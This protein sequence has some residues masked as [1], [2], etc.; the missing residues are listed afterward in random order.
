VL[1]LSQTLLRDGLTFSSLLFLALLVCLQP[2]P[3]TI[4]FYDLFSPMYNANLCNEG[5]DA[6]VILCAA[7]LIRYR[8]EQL[9]YRLIDQKWGMGNI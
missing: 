6:V 1:P 7:M 8:K 3:L 2:S 4:Y 9:R 5:M